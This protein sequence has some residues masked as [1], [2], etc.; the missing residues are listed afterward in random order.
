MRILIVMLCLA[1]TSAGFMRSGNPDN[2]AAPEYDLIITN[3]TVIDGSGTPGF[4]ADVAIKGDRVVKI[5]KLAGATA[6][7]T[8]DARGQIVASGFIDMLGQSEQFLLVD[9]RGM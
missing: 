2:A 9:P 6:T 5:G 7:Q 4:L 1:L 3:G 8:R